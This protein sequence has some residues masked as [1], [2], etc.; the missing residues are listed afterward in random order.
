MT[1][2]FHLTRPLSVGQQKELRLW[3]ALGAERFRDLL[4]FLERLRHGERGNV[5][6]HLS[7]RGPEDGA[8]YMGYVLY[9]CLLHLVSLLLALLVMV[10]LPGNQ[11]GYWAI[12]AF[13]ALLCLGNLW[14]LMLQRYT[15]L[16]LRGLCSRARQ[17]RQGRGPAPGL[18][19]AVGGLA[20][21]ERDAAL[22]LAQRL[23]EGLAGGE[24]LALGREE[25]PAL[26][27]LAGL[28]AELGEKS[29]AP[30]G[31]VLAP[32]GPYSPV[33]RR[34]A[35]LLRLVHSGLR[36]GA[37]GLLT[38]DGEMEKVYRRLA[39]SGRLEELEERLSRLIRELEAAE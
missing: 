24:F 19:A 2:A 14:C 32:E 18:A 6:Y 29:W 34:G 38:S 1:D 27:T 5:N 31:A 30:R 37:F 3:R 15:Y 39:G 10:L 35:W 20:R 8:A 23:S 17:R 28:A 12:M 7:G 13:L 33:E 16:R 9:H 22:S 25:L 21:E 26:E 36:T 4:F 11:R